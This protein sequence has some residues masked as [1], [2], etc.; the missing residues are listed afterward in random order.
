MKKIIFIF[1]AFSAFEVFAQEPYNYLEIKVENGDSWV[2]IRSI[3]L[4]LDSSI[5]ERRLIKNVSFQEFLDAKPDITQPEGLYLTMELENWREASEILNRPHLPKGV[6]N[7]YISEMVYALSDFSLVDSVIDFDRDKFIYLWISLTRAVIS[8][9]NHH[10]S[11]TLDFKH[12]SKEIALAA[13]LIW[14][15]MPKS[16]TVADVN[17]FSLHNPN[18]QSVNLLI[19]AGGN[20]MTKIVVYPEYLYRHRH[21]SYDLVNKSSRDLKY[22]GVSESFSKLK[23]KSRFN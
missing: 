19:D 8:R 2:N 20:I 18:G 23:F 5:F 3:P 4:V 9:N 13:E 12:Q 11:K 6:S 22:F 15:L 10:S 17:V 21:F 7:K 1:L 16:W 14:N